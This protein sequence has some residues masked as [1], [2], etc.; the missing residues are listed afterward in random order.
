MECFNI[1]SNDGEEVLKQE[2]WGIDGVIVDHVLEVVRVARHMD[3]PI[4]SLSASL[5]QKS[6]SGV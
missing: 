6:A 1:C 4:S 5:A 2:K 3:E